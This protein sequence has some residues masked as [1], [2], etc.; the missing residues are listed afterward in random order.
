MENLVKKMIEYWILANFNN[1]L[2]I[3][4]FNYINE[5]ELFHNLYKVSV[6]I[7]YEMDYYFTSFYTVE[8]KKNGICI[9]ELESEND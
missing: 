5:Y 4:S 7:V 2:K 9:I 3:D 1:E 8:V 6:N